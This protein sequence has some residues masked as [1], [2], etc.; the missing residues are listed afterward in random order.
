MNISR[1]N[2]LNRSVLIL[3]L[4]VSLSTCFA[5]QQHKLVIVTFGNSTTA[6]RAG[7]NK[8]Y[9]VRINELLTAAGID[10]TVINAGIGGSHTGSIKDNSF[11]KIEHAMDRFDKSVLNNHPDWVT[12]NFGLNDAYQDQ[13][14]HGPSRIP[15]D[16]YRENLTYFIDQI[17]KQNGHVILLTPN[18]LG[19]KYEIWR[20]NRVKQYM[21]V[22]KKLARKKHIPLINS[23][24]L[25][26]GY[27]KNNPKGIDLLLMDGIHPND[28]GHQ[29][30]ADAIAKIIINSVNNEKVH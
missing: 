27:V 30:I 5:Q 28:T 9:A 24:K 23:W 1:F 26:Y 25:F 4:S 8:V 14:E 15:V 2:F 10:N 11:I 6:P 17:Q 3:L 22:T 16:K 20:Y 7:V 18:P 29:L 19:K 12:M 21:K 13:G